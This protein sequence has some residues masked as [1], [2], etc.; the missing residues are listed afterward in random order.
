MD[1]YPNPGQSEKIC[2]RDFV[3]YSPF[4]MKRISWRK[5]SHPFFI[6]L[7][8][9]RWNIIP[10]NV[11]HIIIQDGYLAAM[12]PRESQRKIK[13]H[14]CGDA[15]P[16]LGWPISSQTS[17]YVRKT[18]LYFPNCVQSGIALLAAQH[19]SQARWWLRRSD[20]KGTSGS[21]TKLARYRNAACDWHQPG[22]GL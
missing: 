4:N 5:S 3:S 12:R 6:F 14:H 13:I 11:Y 8:T 21:H 19:T 16:S 2:W 20:I 17:Y 15:K 10:A 1:L 18:N 22:F 9:I 7:N